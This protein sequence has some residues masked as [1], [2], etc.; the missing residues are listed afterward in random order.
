MVEL[1][2]RD[3]KYESGFKDGKLEQLRVDISIIRE[4]ATESDNFEDFK[5]RLR[6]EIKRMDRKTWF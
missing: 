2:E 5:L 4:L 3:R 6:N 1:L